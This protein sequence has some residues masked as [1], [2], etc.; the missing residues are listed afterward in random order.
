MRRVMYC[1]PDNRLSD[2][3]YLANRTSV[4]VAVRTVEGGDFALPSASV[5][6]VLSFAASTVIHRLADP[7]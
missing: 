3:R 6:A 4:A 2:F 1:A 5:I 7:T